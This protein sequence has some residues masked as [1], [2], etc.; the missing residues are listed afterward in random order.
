M[1]PQPIR[2]NLLITLVVFVA[3]FFFLYLEVIGHYTILDNA[4]LIFHE[5]GHMILGIFGMQFIA[6]IGG[7]LMQLFP[8][9]S[10]TI[11]FYQRH[12]ITASVCCIF[13]LGQNLHNIGNYMADANVQILPLLGGGMHDWN[14]I[15]ST[16]HILPLAEEI[17]FLTQ[18]LGVVTMLAAPVILF[19]LY[20][21]QTSETII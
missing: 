13:W 14:Y 2:L 15:F 18:V 12:D 21:K 8:P 20:R 6:F 4:N 3:M 1:Q 11:Y 16:L 10:T 19:V 17:G 5:A 7:T 9:I